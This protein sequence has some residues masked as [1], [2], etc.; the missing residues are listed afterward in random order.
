[1]PTVKRLSGDKRKCAEHDPEI[2]ARAVNDVMLG[3]LS[4][5]SAEAVYGIK[6]S[7][8]RDHVTGKSASNKIGRNT[9]FTEAEERHIIQYALDMAA[10]GFPLPSSDLIE[11]ARK[12][13]Q[14]DRRKFFLGPK[15]RPGKKF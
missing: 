4:Y 10:M 9:L 8:L 11:E 15:G 13:L 1:M 3:R 6:K 14:R 5:R 12:M 7:T 2:L